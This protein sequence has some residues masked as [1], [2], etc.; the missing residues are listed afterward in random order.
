MR[1]LREEL[2]KDIAERGFAGE[3]ANPFVKDKRP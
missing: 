3:F 2:G 1:F